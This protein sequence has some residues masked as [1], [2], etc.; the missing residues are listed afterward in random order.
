MVSSMMLFD[1][2]HKWKYITWFSRIS[3]ALPLEIEI[4]K[5]D[6]VSIASQVA[7]WVWG[8]L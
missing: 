4:S 2:N 1:E 6:L 8:H 5:D 3:L 7:L